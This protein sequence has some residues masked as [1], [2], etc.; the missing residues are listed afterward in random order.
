MSE[1]E[2]VKSAVGSMLNSLLL[3]ACCAFDDLFFDT[4]KIIILTCILSYISVPNNIKT[5]IE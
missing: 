1:G 3:F 5:M 4:V 2:G